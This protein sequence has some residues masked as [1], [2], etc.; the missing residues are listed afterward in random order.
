MI[1]SK[2][3]DRPLTEARK[4]VESSSLRT[5]EIRTLTVG[6]LADELGVPASEIIVYLMK[7][8][9]I[10]NRNQQ[11]PENIVAELARHFGFDAVKT[12]AAQQGATLGSSGCQ[13]QVSG[14]MSSRAPVIVV[15]GHVDHGKT[16]LLD[17]IR[18]TR[19]AAREKGGITQHLGAYRV[20]T[21][22]GE[23]VFLDT[24]GHEAFMRMR[25]R[26][27]KVADIAIVVIA[28]DDGVMPQTL[29]AI[30]AAR[31]AGVPMIIALNKID[32]ADKVRIDIVK[33]QLSKLGLSLEE[34]GGDVICVPIS[35]KEGRGVDKLLEMID[36]QAQMLELKARASGLGEG[37]VLE[38]RLEKGRGMV[39]TILLR[40]GVLRV[41][42]F[43]IAGPVVGKVSSMMDAAGLMIKEVGPSNPVQV[44]GFEQLPPV[45]EVLRVVSAQE[46]K[47]AQRT[48]GAG[49]VQASV[50]ADVTADEVTTI[51]LKADTESSK[52]ALLSAIAKLASQEKKAVNVVL[53]GVGSLTE[54]DIEFASTAHAL[55]YG[56]GIKPAPYVQMLAKRLGVF[57]ATY[58]V[59]YHLLDDI[60]KHL[61]KLDKPE[62]V[63]KK[64]GEAVV[65]KVFDIK[66][67]IVAGCYVKSGR[68][69]KDGSVVVMRGRRKVGE[70]AIRTLQRDRRTMK[71]VAA[72]YECAFV[73]EGLNDFKVDDVVECFVQEAVSAAK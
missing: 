35:A 63:T 41:G 9:I 65:R 39:A 11:L 15:V 57:L 10:C 44:A 30:N 12:A 33:Q 42:D 59:I 73:G 64:I 62:I 67:T 38:T 51:V 25:S 46:F 68:L 2:K 36:L 4:E 23:I 71:E 56:F 69:T 7:Q 47:D 54:S 45:G 50:G 8:K 21:A 43:F 40:H 28:A 72:G 31:N 14:E 5:F 3:I 24:P 26:G 60:E 32:K 29:E 52:D 19:V 1:P 58:H 6:Q 22:H 70:G 13:A 49:V 53:S 37:F 27:I 55:V 17:F 48:M 20:K 16:T 66:G 34:W 61:K 18:K